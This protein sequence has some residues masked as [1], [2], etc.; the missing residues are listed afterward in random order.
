[1]AYAT[2]TEFQERYPTKLTEAEVTSHFLHHASVRLETMLAPYFTL[3]FS[4]NN[5]TA[6]DI[7]LDLA[8]LLILQRSKDP[9]DA[10]SL[11]QGIKGRI[12]GLRNGTEAMTT[13]SGDTVYSNTGLGEIWSTTQDFKPIFDMRESAE[14]RVDPDRLREEK[15]ADR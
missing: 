11:S 2:Y 10:E 13:T 14:Q 5:L 3:P 6:K 4:A 12:E 15:E 1:M 7:T 9:R 8:Y